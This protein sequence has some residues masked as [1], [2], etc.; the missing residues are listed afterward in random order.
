MSE[1]RRKSKKPLAFYALGILNVI[2]GVLYIF[3]SRLDPQNPESEIWELTG[4]FSLIFGI[5][6]ILLG[7][8]LSIFTS[9][10]EQ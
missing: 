8:L 7:K 3:G 1:K 6:F 9:F 10:K 5:I 2:V 4:I